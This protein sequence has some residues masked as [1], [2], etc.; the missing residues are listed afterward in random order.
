[1]PGRD[2]HVDDYN[3]HLK[4]LQKSGHPPNPQDVSHPHP[5]KIASAP[6]SPGCQIGEDLRRNF[7]WAV[8]DLL[9]LHLS[10]NGAG[11][12]HRWSIIGLKYNS[13]S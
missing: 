4:R 3:K 5:R 2:G 12:G 1:M 13:Q 9:G 6:R 10:V 11:R 8:A 7:T